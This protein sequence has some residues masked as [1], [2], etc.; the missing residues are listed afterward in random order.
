[1]IVLR[2]KL[3][4]P[5]SQSQIQSSD[6]LEGR[7]DKI[8]RSLSEIYTFVQVSKS[9]QPRTLGFPWQGDNLGNTIY[10]EDALGRT[11]DPPA[12]FCRDLRVCSL[13]LF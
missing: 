2:N 1:M 4:C 11:M 8:D 6:R 13:P 5:Q 9:N 3:I 7:L 10:L 12:I